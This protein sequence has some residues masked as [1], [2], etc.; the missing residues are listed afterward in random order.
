M[1][2]YLNWIEYISRIFEK[3]VIFIVQ[4]SVGVLILDLNIAVLFRIFKVQLVGTSEI[5]LFLL[6][7]ITFLG[8]SLSIKQGSMVAITVI[9]ERLKGHVSTSVQIIIQLFVLFFSCILFYYSFNWITAPN[10]QS[11]LSSALQ[12]PMWIPYSIIPLSTLLTIIFCIS[13]IVQLLKTESTT[14]VSDYQQS[15]EKEWGV[16]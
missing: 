12:I 7:W 15:I 3:M 2:K 10:V 4:V 16:E 9:L 1:M 11:T 13:N 6:A 14:T 5:A 8:A